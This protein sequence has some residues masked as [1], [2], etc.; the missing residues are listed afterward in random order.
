[1]FTYIVRL[2]TEILGRISRDAEYF[3]NLVAQRYIRSIFREASNIVSDL[4]WNVH[5]KRDMLLTEPANVDVF[6]GSSGFFKSQQINVS[7][8]MHFMKWNV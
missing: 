7:H 4:F 6:P 1:M 2:C 3:A 5:S 8:Q